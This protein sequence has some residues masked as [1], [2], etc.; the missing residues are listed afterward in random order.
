VSGLGLAMIARY[1][2]QRMGGFMM[3]AYFVA[4]GLSQYLGSVVA[5]VAHIPENLTNAVQSLTIYTHLFNELGLAGVVCTVI[6]I[7]M[8]PF[9]KKLSASHADTTATPL[10]AV[11]SEEF[12][13]TS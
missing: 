1:V 13:P 2:P 11:R 3:G 4:S 10:P 7:A 5:N 12:N 6:A 8:L 9:M